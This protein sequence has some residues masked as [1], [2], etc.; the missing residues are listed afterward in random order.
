VYPDIP[1]RA[2]MFRAA[3]SSPRSPQ[4]SPA[5]PFWAAGLSRGSGPRVWAATRRS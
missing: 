2:V 1:L 3:P 5:A 4:S